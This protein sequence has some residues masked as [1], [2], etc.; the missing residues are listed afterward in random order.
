MSSRRPS[1]NSQRARYRVS[2]QFPFPSDGYEV[3]SLV[4]CRYR[5]LTFRDKVTYAISAMLSAFGNNRLMPLPDLDCILINVASG[6]ARQNRSWLLSRLLRDSLYWIPML[7]PPEMKKVEA[8]KLAELEKANKRLPEQ[9]RRTRIRIGLRVTV[10]KCDNVRGTGGHDVVFWSG[11]IVF[12]V[13]LLCFGLPPLLLYGDYFAVMITTCGTALAWL[14]SALPQWTEEKISVRPL[15]KPKDVLLTEGAGSH[16]ILMLRVQPGDL[17]LEALASFQRDLH[18]PRLTRILSATLALCWIALLITVAGWEEHT[19]Y[20]LGVG[21]IG[22]MHNVFVAGWERKPAALGIPLQYENI[23]VD[24][25]VMKVLWRL[26]AAYPRAGSS[27][28]ATFFPGHLREAE[29][30]A[31]ELAAERF[32]DWKARGYPKKTDG[33]PNAWQ[34]PSSQW[35]GEKNPD[36]SIFHQPV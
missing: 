15:E 34:L 35:V 10:W 36:L 16:D 4:I 27:A 13:Q 28:I 12:L 5:A 9:D 25:K 14:S 23:F 20:I 32:D 2:V 8:E 19:W 17:D 6:Y 7:L 30:R 3:L 24:D 22:I 11:V 18:Q 26:E 1:R 33:S 21:I 29:K 31:W